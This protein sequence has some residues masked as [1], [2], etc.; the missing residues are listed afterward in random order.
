MPLPWSGTAA[1]ALVLALTPTPASGQNAVPACSPEAGVAEITGRP[2]PQER[3]RFQRVWRLSRGEGVTVAV[4]DSGVDASHPQLSGVVSGSVDL[5]GTGER[6]CVGHGTAVAGII[7]G[8]DLTSRGIPFLGVA[9]GAR[10][11]DVKQTDT[12]DGEVTKLAEGIR[13]AAELGAKVINVSVTAHDLPE[14]KSAVA[15]AQ[16]R[17]AVIVAAAGNVKREDGAVTPAYP[18]SYPGVI[19]VGSASRDGRRSEF[20]NSATRVS[21]T[22]PG[23]EIT[24][25]WTGGGYRADLDGTSFAAPYVSGV[26]ALV[27][28]RHPELDH[29]QV[30]RRVELTA[31]GGGA[32]GTGAGLVNP[33]QAVSAVLPSAAEQPAGGARP[34]VVA[35]RPT[36][37]EETRNAA[38]GIAGAALGATGLVVFVSLTVP[39]ARRRGW[40]AGLSQHFQES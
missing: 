5:T 40:R 4:V 38:A 31:E 28:A 18:A 20:S 24:S 36:P 7:A 11:L 17:D 3:L 37:D 27:R 10:I 35:K 12:Q 8:R 6:D 2:W 29:W 33:M 25:T 9:P 34:V 30:K 39:R 16:S 1:V 23:A 26:V 19:A 21:V 13:R 14:L 15:Y 32:S 22:A